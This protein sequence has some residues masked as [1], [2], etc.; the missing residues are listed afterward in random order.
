METFAMKEI[1]IP[2]VYC[3]QCPFFATG[4]DADGYCDIY[5]EQWELTEKESECADSLKP[6][7]CKAVRVL[8]D[9]DE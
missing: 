1:L 2:K 5:G 6:K 8:V 3:A 9:E 7:F 4:E